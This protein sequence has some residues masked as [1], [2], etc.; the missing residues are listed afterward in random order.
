M[1]CFCF[2]W[3]VLVALGRVVV[4]GCGGGGRYRCSGWS[5]GGGDDPDPGSSMTAGGGP[6]GGTVDDVDDGEDDG[7]VGNVGG[8]SRRCSDRVSGEAVNK[9]CTETLASAG[10]M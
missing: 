2:G 7:A 1:A 8:T 3:V 5:V 10:L 4:V 6:G 9:S